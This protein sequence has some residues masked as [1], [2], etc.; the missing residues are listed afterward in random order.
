MRPLRYHSAIKFLVATARNLVPS[1]IVPIIKACRHAGYCQHAYRPSFPG[2]FTFDVETGCLSIE[3]T[4]E[5]DAYPYALF[6]AVILESLRGQ[7]WM[8]KWTQNPNV[9][10]EW[11]G[12]NRNIAWKWAERPVLFITSSERVVISG[13]LW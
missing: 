1:K 9:K 4:K 5:I 6:Y 10:N 3:K 8:L 12:R 13:F 2:I 11:H 7:W